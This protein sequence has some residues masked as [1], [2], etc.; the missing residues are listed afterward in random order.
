MVFAVILYEKATFRAGGLSMKQKLIML[1]FM[2]LGVFYRSATVCKGGE[3]ITPQLIRNH[4][5]QE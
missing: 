2:G 3:G 5:A 4:K 1:K